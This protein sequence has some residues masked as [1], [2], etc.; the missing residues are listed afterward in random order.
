[1]NNKII[2]INRIDIIFKYYVY[3]LLHEIIKQIYKI[4]YINNNIYLLNLYQ[5]S[6]FIYPLII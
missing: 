3:T 2:I 5:I 6:F 4:I 1:M